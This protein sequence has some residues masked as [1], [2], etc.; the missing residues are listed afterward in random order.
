MPSPY[1]TR[2][3]APQFSPSPPQRT[4]T[5]AHVAASQAFAI[6]SASPPATPLFGASIAPIMT[7]DTARGMPPA[8]LSLS[9]QRSPPPATP[10]AAPRPAPASPPAPIAVPPPSTPHR[11]PT[12]L[13]AAPS[14]DLALN[15]GTTP[16]PSPTPSQYGDDLPQSAPLSDEEEDEDDSEHHADDLAPQPP[17]DQADLLARLCSRE[18]IKADDL[19][20][21]QHAMDGM[22]WV[23]H[24][25][26]SH[27]VQIIVRQYCKNFVANAPRSRN[28]HSMLLVISRHLENYS[29]T[30]HLI[31]SG[32]GRTDPLAPP[33]AAAANGGAVNN[34]ALMHLL[35]DHAW[36]TQLLFFLRLV[37]QF[38][39]SNLAYDATLRFFAHLAAPDVKPVTPKANA[40]SLGNWAASPST[41]VGESTGDA[42]SRRA[43]SPMN[44]TINL[45]PNSRRSSLGLSGASD[46]LTRF[47]CAIV[48]VLEVLG[49]AP[50]N[51][52]A[53]NGK[54]GAPLSTRNSSAPSVTSPTAKASQPIVDLHLELLNTLFVMLSTQ[55]YLPLSTDY[56][57]VFLD[58]L[59]YCSKPPMLNSVQ[60]FV[61]GLI[62]TFTEILPS[63]WAT[64]IA[65][66]KAPQPKSFFG[67]ITSGLTNLLYFPVWAVRY[68]F[69]IPPNHPLIDRATLLIELLVY[70]NGDNEFRSAIKNL[71]NA[72]KPRPPVAAP[73]TALAASTAAVSRVPSLSLSPSPED[74]SENSTLDNFELG[75]VSFDKLYYALC[76]TLLSEHINL[77]LYSLIHENAS[78]RLYLLRH[79]SHDLDYLLMPM[80]EIL[81]REVDI[82]KHHVYMIV[83]IWILLTQH[84][85]FDDVIKTIRVKEV[86]F[87]KEMPLKD[88]ALTEVMQAVLLRTIQLNLKT[89]LREPHIF[90]NLAA[91]FCNLTIT[92]ILGPPSTPLSSGANSPASAPQSPNGVF[93]SASVLA[94]PL[95][96]H[97]QVAFRLTRV[98]CIL[99][100]KFLSLQ[101]LHETQI[102]SHNA[103]VDRMQASGREELTEEEDR[104]EVELEEVAEE[105]GTCMEFIQLLLEV[106]N[107]S[108]VHALPPPMSP[109]NIAPPTMVSQYNHHQQQ[110]SSPVSSLARNPHLLYNLLHSRE[111]F[112]QLLPYAHLFEPHLIAN[113]AN[114]ILF[115]ANVPGVNI[116]AGDAGKLATAGGQSGA[117]AGKRG[118]Q[119]EKE[120][121]ASVRALAQAI[122]NTPLS[123]PASS[124]V[125]ASPPSGSTPV[126]DPSALIERGPFTY[127]EQEN[128][129]DFFIPYI[130][131][132]AQSMAILP[133]M[134]APSDANAPDDADDP[135]VAADEETRAA[136]ELAQASSALGDVNADEIFMSELA[137]ELQSAQPSPVDG[138]EEEIVDDFDA[139][140]LRPYQSPQLRAMTPAIEHD[141]TKLNIAIK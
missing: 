102:A 76:S 9:P 35:K 1:V 47:V 123:R 90:N 72:D 24:D 85:G 30:L 56:E 100:R 42:G 97:P 66:K 133:K 140:Q 51:M 116:P 40:N 43:L 86:P 124:P 89:K 36:V 7:N 113:V 94:L 10:H 131:Q 126:F 129:Q 46:I 63:D 28:L 77:F 95:T 109:L 58:R 93:A 64:T 21:W 18:R 104:E 26:H 48:N 125:G 75:A 60:G 2:I 32:E 73:G 59:L 38:I 108:I 53:A 22:E 92:A 112:L 139:A 29:Q 34:A 12:Q 31:V 16:T 82:S 55:M 27:E 120:A 39:L 88:M 67:K 115:Y 65:H 61:T 4:D 54:A 57:Q 8:A 118:V 11:P 83:N 99:S 23:L 128:S 87:F 14:P 25:T 141:M 110:S 20:F 117:G 13:L 79:H 105:L 103:R 33:A 119:S 130:Y 71:R 62:S 69:T 136:L 17:V 80:L 6:A 96:L 49:D 81:Y 84:A 111:Y 41:T 135:A 74:Y 114:V 98:L 15:F 44:H 70:Q 50:L 137:D 138:E 134:Y 101:S 106:V 5:A 132:L 91:A 78:F 45:N 3:S 37:L 121:E 19:N 122:R 127:H 107:H 68:L 52:Q